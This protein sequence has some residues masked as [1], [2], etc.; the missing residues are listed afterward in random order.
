MIDVI[1][2]H[3]LL[4]NLDIIGPL[5]ELTAPPYD[6]ISPAQQE[7]LYQKNPYN[8]VRLILG[9]EYKNDSEN[10]NRYT[11][12]AKV[13]KDWTNQ[14]VLKKDDK[15][16]YYLYSQEYEFEG[17]KFYR[18][19]FFARVGLQNFSEGNICPHEFTLS[20]A[21]TDRTRLLSA[22]H[23]NFSPIFGLYSDPKGEIDSFLKE[24]I[25]K[26]PLFRV[27]DGLV[28]HK[29]WRMGNA[30]KNQKIS[31]L[32]H[33]KKIYIADGH[34]RYETALAFAQKNQGAVADNSHVM[35][36]LTNM[37]SGSMSI[38][39]IHRVVKS[40]IPFDHELFLKR[41]R[42]YFNVIP[43]TTEVNASEIKNRLIE[44][45]KDCI[46]FCAYMGR[47][48]TFT[49]IA[50]DSKKILPLLDGDEP[51]DLKVLDVMQLHV[52]IFREILKI[53]TRKKENQEYVSYKVNSEEAMKIVDSGKYDVA[54]F[55]NPTK[56]KEVR[57][58]AGMGIR[59]PQKAT[60]FY[61]KLLSGL[62]INKFEK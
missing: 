20:K 16:G 11:R 30:E 25:K 28:V 58:L 40:P 12:S 48:K 4:Y 56:I 10:D 61:P 17:K 1:P 53:D 33:D 31:E 14:G 35:M 24:V 5:E 57:R 44:L 62:V 32:I 54:F 13:F 2:F 27:D 45:G 42:E 51:K 38:F 55:M 8:V 46:T 9:K 19:G 7:A 34:H 37:D 26:K 59:L 50:N 22:C 36:F 23:A 41:I 6:V 29:L 47:G 60:F 49:L 52:I 3:G 39:P 18:I 21:K 15:P 43:W